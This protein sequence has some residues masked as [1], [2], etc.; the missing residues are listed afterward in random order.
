MQNQYSTDDINVTTSN[1]NES[2]SYN[3]NDKNYYKNQKSHND[4]EASFMP[5]LTPHG[6]PSSN[7]LWSKEFK[8]E[9][10]YY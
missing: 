2:F 7:P 3:E 5:V 4:N 8:K 10:N 9:N 6:V 1:N